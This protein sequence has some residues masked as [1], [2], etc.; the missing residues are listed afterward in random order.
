MLSY[1]VFIFI[2]FVVR[3]YYEFP[4]WNTLVSAI[5]ISSIIFAFA[6]FFSGLAAGQLAAFRITKELYIT[7]EKSLS[8]LRQKLDE[9]NKDL[10]E[11]LNEEF[12]AKTGGNV[13]INTKTNLAQLSKENESIKT[14]YIKYDTQHKKYS[15]LS[16][17]LSFLG[18]LSFFVMLVFQSISSMF[19]AYLE[20]LS[21]LAFGLIL[22]T[23]YMAGYFEDIIEQQKIKAKNVHNSVIAY[24]DAESK[25]ID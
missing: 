13:H 14:M 22:L 10:T 1:I 21:V 25:L 7:T 11:K 3:A 15:T 2:C 19:S 6:D 18:Y 12:F 8:G 17:I 5:S 4:M 20:L 23:Q 16:N 24:V 9:M